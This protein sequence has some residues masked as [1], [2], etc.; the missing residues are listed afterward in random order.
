VELLDR[1]AGR[2]GRRDDIADE[3]FVLEHAGK[4]VLR[5]QRRGQPATVGV[6]QQEFDFMADRGRDAGFG[7]RGLDPAQRSPGARGNGCAVLLEE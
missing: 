6:D 3:G 2:R 1:D 4:A 5:P 7:E